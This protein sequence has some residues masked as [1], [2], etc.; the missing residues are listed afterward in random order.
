MEIVT[1]FA[2]TNIISGSK[3]LNKDFPIISWWSN[4]LET[5]AHY[6][7]GCAVEISIK[8]DSNEKQEYIRDLSDLQDDSSGYTYGFEEMLYPEGAIWY[9]FSKSYLEKN[10]IEIKEIFPDLNKYS[11]V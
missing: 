7:E 10:V 1:I 11:E 6:Y 4:N 3:L 9:S 5:L 2:G 8:L